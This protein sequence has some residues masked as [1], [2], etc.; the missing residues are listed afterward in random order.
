M[1]RVERPF[2]LRRREAG[3]DIQTAAVRLRVNPHYLR[4]VELGHA[5]LSIR[6]ANRMAVVYGTTIRLLTEPVSP[7][8]GGTGRGRESSGNG[9]LPVGEGVQ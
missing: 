1:H 7:G 5:P 4:T 8:A 2:A 3:F 6:M 9:S